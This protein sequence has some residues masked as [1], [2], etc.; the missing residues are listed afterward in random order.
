MKPTEAAALLTI[1]AAYDNRR[2]DPDAAKAWAMALDGLRFEDCR[3]VIVEH[4]QRS[5]DWMMPVD[6]I[7][8]VKRLRAQR[9]SEFGPMPE[10][11]HGLG[12]DPAA[13]SR[14]YSDTRRAIGDGAY[15]GT[16][17]REAE[18]AAHNVLAEL[19]QAGTSVSAELARTKRIA[20]EAHQAARAE[21][22]AAIKP[23]PQPLLAPEDHSREPEPTTEETE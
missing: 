23:E 10:P 18:L 22:Q 9:I 21:F 1:A 20:R 11:P 14:W 13:Y 4:Y 19:G 5:R 3:Q 12:E 15:D 17:Q 16:P 8:G 2:P 7:G 6:V